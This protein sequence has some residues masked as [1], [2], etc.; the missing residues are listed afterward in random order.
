MTSILAFF[1]YSFD[2]IDFMADRFIYS[3][4]GDVIAS[5]FCSESLT[6]RFFSI[7]SLTLVPMANK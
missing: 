6:E 2:L 4:A 1:T 7:N 5:K 3:M